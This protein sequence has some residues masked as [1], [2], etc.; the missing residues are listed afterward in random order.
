[1][2]FGAAKATIK[3]GDFYLS[4]S[5]FFRNEGFMVI[6]S[7]NLEIKKSTLNIGSHYQYGHVTKIK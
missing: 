6:D 3:L 7:S 1:M 2:S 5:V 4:R